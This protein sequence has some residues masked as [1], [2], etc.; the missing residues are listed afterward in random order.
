MRDFKSILT[1]FGLGD[2]T[3][4]SRFG[5]GLVNG[6]YHVECGGERY[7]LQQVSERAFPD[8]V[9]VIH[10]AAAVSDYLRSRREY[11]LSTLEFLKTSGGEY[12]V[13]SDGY[14]RVSRM[15]ENSY[16]ASSF[17]AEET[18]AAAFAFAE[19]SAA[20]DGMPEGTLRPAADDFHNTEKRFEAFI[21]AEENDACGRAG[22]AEYWR[23]FIH[24]GKEKINR[25]TDGLSD[26]TIPARYVHNDTKINNILFDKDSGQPIC[27]ID[28]DTVARSS[29]L[30]DFGDGVRSAAGRA[31][32]SL[33][34][35]LFAAFAKGY[36]AG[37][38]RL[39]QSEAALLVYSVW[40]MCYECGMRF[41]TD[42]FDGDRYFK[43]DFPDENF[44]RAVKNLKL[45]DFCRAHS[46]QMQ[47]IL[48]STAGYPRGA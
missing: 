11:R 16:T 46:D 24:A 42:Y 33:D 39:E 8:P 31:D 10:N 5:G 4:I 45:A 36:V 25:I 47:D 13:Q 22:H 26:N 32:G 43:T 6:T 41:L 18:R 40:L 2:F 27:V 7:V 19:F 12:Y 14:F 1:E 29:V 48:D 23:E 3:Q 28:L 30:Y 15:V 9:A 38:G 35:D 37:F 44:A 17:S 34:L 21:Q 20:L